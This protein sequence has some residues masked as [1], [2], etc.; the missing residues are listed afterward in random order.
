MACAEHHRL[1]TYSGNEAW[2][3]LDYPRVDWNID[4]DW[5][6]V[7]EGPSRLLTVCMMPHGDDLPRPMRLDTTDYQLPAG[8]P[9]PIATD[10]MHLDPRAETEWFR[11][12]YR[13]ELELAAGLYE[14]PPEVRWGLVVW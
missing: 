7:G 10:W 13:A 1:W 9:W 8:W 5:P 4:Q 12:A 11:T 3:R 2:E 6:G 14:R